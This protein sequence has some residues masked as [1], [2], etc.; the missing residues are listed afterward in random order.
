MAT[1]T[2][3]SCAQSMDKIHD[4]TVEKCLPESISKSGIDE[5]TEFVISEER[6]TS[7][8]EI[9]FD[10]TSLEKCE[11]DTEGENRF[12]KHDQEDPVNAE[13]LSL[14]CSEKDGSCDSQG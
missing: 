14:V 6:E 1:A 4:R 13:D 8:N 10:C 11:S 9:E 7:A 2:P 3:S 5:Q 12:A